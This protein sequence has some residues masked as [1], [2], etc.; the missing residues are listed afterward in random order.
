MLEEFDKTVATI[1]LS[2]KS[3]IS[4]E[5]ISK[6]PKQMY[7]YVQNQIMK[8]PA[9]AQQ[10]FVRYG[11]TD[12]K[13]IFEQYLM[14]EKMNLESKMVEGEG[15]N[16]KVRKSF[17]KKVFE[18][19]LKE[20]EAEWNKEDYSADEKKKVKD[21][22]VLPYYFVALEHAYNKIKKDEDKPQEKKDRD[23]RRKER[24]ARGMPF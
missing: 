24:R 17:L 18:N 21:N 3:I 7:T 12:V 10:S 4:L 1:D 15:E 5:E 9:W 22:N 6:D 16:R 14:S 23:V 8:S 19:S 2:N 20:A 11:E 13:I